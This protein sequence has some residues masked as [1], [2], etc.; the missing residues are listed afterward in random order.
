M[1]RAGK[2]EPLWAYGAAEPGSGACSVVVYR[3]YEAALHR[4]AGSG[5]VRR[6]QLGR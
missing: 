2:A 5:E 6:A 1:G 3:C 4:V